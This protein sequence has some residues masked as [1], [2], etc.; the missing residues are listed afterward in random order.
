VRLIHRSV[1]R[2]V[3]GGAVLLATLLVFGT[4]AFADSD[5][6]RPPE[7]VA[8]DHARTIESPREQ[9]DL[10]GGSVERGDREE[11][12]DKERPRDRPDHDRDSPDDGGVCPP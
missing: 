1:A 10:R 8:A 3:A 4:P 2:C 11:P 9:A 6:P 5:S 7:I 12:K